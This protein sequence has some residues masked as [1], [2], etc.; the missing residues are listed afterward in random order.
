MIQLRRVID[1]KRAGER[2]FTPNATP[3]KMTGTRL[4]ALQSKR[5][6]SRLCHYSN[7]DQLL[8]QEAQRLLSP[9]DSG[10]QKSDL[11]MISHQLQ[12]VS[13]TPTC[14]KFS[15][16][17]S[18]CA[19]KREKCYDQLIVKPQSHTITLEVTIPMNSAQPE[20]H[21]DKFEPYIELRIN[22][23]VFF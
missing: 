2:R 23:F 6:S 3:M 5:S 11:P 22:I 15:P 21:E 4:A 7:V 1:A 12:K 14:T 19:L 8:M 13:R 18:K 16:Y 9:V 20:E 17:K 10:H